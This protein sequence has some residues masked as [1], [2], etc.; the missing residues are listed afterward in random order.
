MKITFAIITAGDQDDR[1]RE[2]VRSI[3]ATMIPEYEILVVGGSTTT[4]DEPD[5]RHISFDEGQRA[6]WITRKKN[7]ATQEAAHDVIVYLHDYH[8][9]DPDWYTG[10]TEFGT[11]WDIQCHSVLTVEGHRCFDWTTWDHPTIPSHINVPYDRA[12]LVPYQYLSGGYWVSKRHV[13]LEE[14]L[15]ENRGSFQEEDVEWSLRVRRKYRIVMNSTCVVRH[16]KVHRE[17]RYA[18]EREQR[19]VTYFD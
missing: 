14:P 9:F 19:S 1:I 15:D 2:I 13:V 10:M 8:V 6:G 17:T 4:L 7:L 16:N 18:G 3:R 12:D 11:D 5:V